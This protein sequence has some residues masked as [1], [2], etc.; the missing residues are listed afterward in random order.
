MRITKRNVGFWLG[1]ALF[2]IINYL[3]LFQ[4]LNAQAI[5]VLAVA[6]WVAVWWISEAIS[7]SAT[8]MLPIA[9]F[10]LTGGLSLTQ[11]TAAYGHP[12]IFLFLGGFILAIAI[13]KWGLHKRIALTI[14][15]VIGSNMRN[16]LLG[17]MAATAF[18]SMWISNTAAA[19]ML[20][21]VGIA[22]VK[23]QSHTPAVQGMDTQENPGFGKALM[24]AIAYAA[25]IGGM[26]TLIGT[27]PNLVLAGVVRESYGVE[28]S[29]LQ[30]MLIA[31]PFSVVLLLIVWYYLSHVAFRLGRQSLP[32]GRE[33]I[34]RQLKALGNMSKQERAVGLVFLFMAL[35]WVF[36][37]F[38]L[39]QVLPGL[40]D[41][42]IAVIGAVLLFV[43]PAGEGKRL[44]DWDDTMRLPWGVIVLFGG[45][46]ALASGFEQSGL[47]AW[48]GNQLTVFEQMPAWLLLVL[49]VLSVNFLTEITSNLATTAMILPILVSLAGPMGIHPYL[50]LTSATLAAS[51]A[52]MLPVATPPN[53]LVFSAG[54]LRIEEM[55][56]AGFW[57]NLIST[58]VLSLFIYLLL[59][60]L[61]DLKPLP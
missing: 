19:V 44:I 8:A 48:I 13:E 36:R 10:P 15:A 14:I 50:L 38:L 20:L 52:F 46:L 30:W 41:T 18:L 2:V 28:I 53:A 32:G 42:I 35:S 12:Y 45:G 16:I 27:P 51:C 17:F 55:V 47:A 34:G 25:S 4:G 5:A 49:L 11:T 21:P 39:V 56:K 26:A 31:L 24:L 58:L 6:A 23:H 59:P 22:I 61:W 60:L 43:L 1:P 57:L 29:F 40:D 9:L 7:I 33:E 3:P 54:Y 37:S